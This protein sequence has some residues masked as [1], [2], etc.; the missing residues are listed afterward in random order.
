MVLHLV[1]VL[2]FILRAVAFLIDWIVVLV[3]FLAIASPLGFNVEGGRAQ[4]GETIAGFWILARSITSASG[5]GAARRRAR[6]R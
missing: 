2:L 3:V 1:D 4:N 5:P 6:S